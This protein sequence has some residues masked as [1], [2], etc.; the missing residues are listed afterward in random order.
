MANVEK[1]PRDK[2]YAYDRHLSSP[3]SVNEREFYDKFP[4]SRRSEFPNWPDDAFR[5]LD[6]GIV[7]G[8]NVCQW[9]E[10]KI[11]SSNPKAEATGKE[12]YHRALRLA[13]ESMNVQADVLFNQLVGF[14]ETKFD[15]IHS[16]VKNH[17][18]IIGSV[19][20]KVQ[21]LRIHEDITTKSE[22]LA[23]SFALTE[24]PWAIFCGSMVLLKGFPGGD[25][26]ISYNM[27]LGVLDKIEATF[28]F[29]LYTVSASQSPKFKDVDYFS[30]AAKLHEMLESIYN[31]MGVGANGIFKILEAICAG[32][33]LE[34]LDPE[35]NDVE[36]LKRTLNELAVEKPRM[37]PHALRV[38]DYFRTW[39]NVI[40]PLA[41]P[42]VMD[43]YG[44][45]KLHFFPI[46]DD[47][48]GLIKMY[49]YGTAYRQSQRNI[50]EILRGLAAR[51]FT[52]SY[53]EKE[54]RLPPIIP[55]C[56]NDQ[57]LLKWWNSGTLPYAKLCRIV[58]AEAWADLTFRKLFDFDYTTDPLD[59]LDD[60]SCAPYRRN[61]HQIYATAVRRE[62][63]MSK[64][65]KQSTRRLVEYLLRSKEIDIKNLFDEVHKEDRLPYDMTLILLSMKE[66]ENKE[67]ARPFSILHPTLRMITSSLEKNIS[68]SLYPYF[69]QQTMT[70][71]GAT[72]T[73]D[74]DHMA[75]KLSSDTH[76][77][78][79]FHIDLE[80][81]NY[82]FREKV[83]VGVQNWMNELFGV[84]HYD[85]LMRP[86]KDAF[87]TSADS[88]NPYVRQDR[89]TSWSTYPGGNQGI[90]QKF[91]T[92]ITILCIVR[93]MTPVD[94][95]HILK[96]SGDN[97]V[98]NVSI[99]KTSNVRDECARI[100]HFLERS[101][102]L[103]GLTV[104]VHETWHSDKLLAYQRKY[105][106]EGQPLPQGCKTSTRFASGDNEGADS[107][108]MHTMTAMGAGATLSAS[109]ADPAIGPLLGLI[110][111]YVG[112]L[113]TP[114]WSASLSLNDTN[115]VVLSWM[116]ASL[117]YLPVQPL[118]FFQYSGHK[119]LLTESLAL[120][121]GIMQHH[122]TYKSAI[123]R[124]LCAR[125]K[126]V[127]DESRLQLILDIESPNIHRPVTAETFIQEAVH[128][129]LTSST[130]VINDR[131]REMFKLLRDKP[132]HDLANTL[133]DIRPRNMS[134]CHALFDHSVVGRVKAV[135]NKF[136]KVKTIVKMT[137]ENRRRTGEE[138][139]EVQVR[140][141]D[142][143]LLNSIK[144]IFE[145]PMMTQD[146]AAKALLCSHWTQ[147]ERWCSLHNLDPFCTLSARLSI[148]VISHG[149]GDGYLFGPYTAAPSE[150][151][152]FFNNLSEVDLD[153]AI[154]VTPSRNIPRSHERLELVRGPF[155][156]YVGS[157]TQETVRTLKYLDLSGV[158]NKTSIQTLT[159]LHAWFKKCGSSDEIQNF[160]KGQLDQRLSGLAPLLDMVDRHAAGGNIGHRLAIPG[161]VMGAYLSSRTIASTHYRLSTDKAITLQRGE[162]DRY[163]FFQQLF[164]WI[165]TVLRWTEPLTNLFAVEVRLD[166]CGYII[167]EQSFE[168]VRPLPLPP[169]LTTQHLQLSDAVIDKVRQALEHELW[170]RRIDT[171]FDPTVEERIASALACQA[172]Q[173]LRKY[174]RG[175]SGS[176][177]PGV[178]LRPA[179]NMFNLTLVR[180]VSTPMLLSSLVITWAY[181][182]ALGRMM[183]PTQLMHRLRAIVSSPSTL[184]E[185]Q[186]HAPILEALSATGKIPD[187]AVMTDSVPKW[188]RSDANRSHLDLFFRAILVVTIDIIAGKRVAPFAFVLSDARADR[189]RLHRFLLAWSKE[190]RIWSGIRTGASPLEYLALPDSG[191]MSIQPI[192]AV[193]AEELIEKA[194]GGN[195]TLDVAPPIAHE[196]LIQMTKPKDVSIVGFYPWARHNGGDGD[197]P[198]AHSTATTIADFI[199]PTTSKIPHDAFQ[200]LRWASNSSGGRLK[201]IE[202]LE[203]T[204]IQIPDDPDIVT[205][206]EGAASMMSAFLHI[207]PTAKGLYNSLV[208]PEEL[209]PSAFVNFT[210]PELV[211]KCGVDDRVLNIPYIDEDYGDLDKRGPWNRLREQMI[212]E[213]S[214]DVIVTWDRE[215]SAESMEIGLEHLIEFSFNSQVKVVIVKLWASTDEGI[216]RNLYR[217]MSRH[218]PYCEFVKPFVSNPR[219]LE[220][221]GIWGRNKT[222]GGTPTEDSF[223]DWVEDLPQHLEKQTAKTFLRQLDN[224]LVWL[225]HFL[226]CSV[227]DP[228]TFD[229]TGELETGP[230]AGAVQ[231]TRVL[232]HIIRARDQTDTGLARSFQHMTDANS[233]G[234][235]VTIDIIR[236]VLVAISCIEMG[237]GHSRPEASGTQILSIIRSSKPDWLEQCESAINRFSSQV[238][239]D[240]TWRMVRSVFGRAG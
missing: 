232:R 43:C 178:V 158:D 163:I 1:E 92:F 180:S 8:T 116:T 125:V 227:K 155:A 71:S 85:L 213:L 23:H 193:S 109:L 45:E 106:Y 128:T 168:A 39:L 10:N 94:L 138:S 135:T 139:F 111:W 30:Q 66:R 67:A 22:T 121:D 100:K 58:P 7:D 204:N 210:P 164:H 199:E 50:S 132:Q 240:M 2:P 144:T 238:R 35:A 19:S 48:A 167:P 165:F 127:D 90:C 224:A 12:N 134:V 131:I 239:R 112:L 175:M 59:F 118:S 63:G 117:G 145:V 195:V 115:L 40:G 14:V 49:R 89:F 61:L 34:T 26:A 108:T 179:R 16:I 104:K 86:F 21:V 84:K 148:M 176:Y 3:L 141:K 191:C 172:S 136:V 201:L 73:S 153:K 222:M 119:D 198:S 95:P 123:S 51:E 233:Q 215:G 57:R 147:H 130:L 25:L 161:D 62:Y 229:S 6:K 4:L 72:L 87:F 93:G 174:Q 91:W 79:K 234:T 209:A 237:L 18:K 197:D 192:P 230:T 226:P 47:E 142:R 169:S 217:K 149:L 27:F 218:F 68:Q 77:E 152:S 37:Y 120:L 187:L 133:L 219:S 31:Q 151:L 56:G 207:Y 28:H 32:A 80:Q 200:M 78:V 189:R 24:C 54:G 203:L 88:F 181:Q 13:V 126:R 177:Q 17:P 184:Q 83:T 216:L 5:S 186:A 223:M 60:K 228:F 156:L 202:L 99:P 76:A 190:Y 183:S 185:M 231:A 44:Q 205:L 140:Q 206:A 69:P 170:V 103:A 162:D 236:S 173:A 113:C 107:V 211:C 146:R 194:R 81:W 11:S 98:L 42:A 166:H 102:G 137:N 41:I 101:F 9:L 171:K 29:W 97:Q 110:E 96:G 74:V 82:T 46:I 235:Q 105:Y 114:R 124:A 75:A 188:V 20:P 129:Y 212:D 36:F 53:Y 122:P 214:E 65:P 182:G 220:F 157:T 159:K 154:I 221:F 52:I 15:D 33:V 64:S 225:S 55:M 150:Q 38:A 70:S 208:S 196:N 160:I 143:L